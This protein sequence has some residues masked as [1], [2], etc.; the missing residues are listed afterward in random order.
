MSFQ[1]RKIILYS[2]TGATRV[3]L[4][5]PNSVNIITGASKTGKS[6]LIHIVDY[7]LGR[8]K[9]RIP[10]VIQENVSWFG[11]H[12][13]RREEELFVA[14]RNPDPG[15]LSSEDIYIEKGLDLKVPDHNELIQ[16]VNLEGLITLLNDFSGITEYSFDTKPEHTREVGT[17]NITKAL[18]YC[19]Q[20]QSEVANQYFL[21]HRQG[22]QFIPQSIKDYMPFFL[23]AVN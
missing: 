4:L 17:A 14:R 2:K 12:L 16:N 10:G 11:V 19:F 3:L 6:A 7:C 15:K 22:E 5:Q 1:I 13:V 18:I 8:T 20:E 21:F 9:S 23:G